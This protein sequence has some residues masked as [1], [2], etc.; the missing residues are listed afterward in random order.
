MLSS[1]GILSAASAAREPVRTI[2]SGP[3]GGVIG[4]L[5][6]AR[7]T[8]ID[9]ILTFDMG[10]TSTDVSLLDSTREPS[11]S[12][13]GQV[14]GLPVGIPM[15]DIHTAGAGGGSLAWIDGAGTLQVGPQSAGAAPGPACYGRGDRATVTDANL[16][17]GRLHPNHF[18]GGAMRLDKSRARKA[19][20]A[21]PTNSFATL[22]HFAEGILRVANAHMEAALRRVS[23]ERGHDPRNFT[24]LAFG[25][26]GPLHACGLAD[27][28][29]I[30]RVLIPAVPGALSA[31][32]IL[33]ADLRREFSRTVMLPLG[34]PQIANVFR[35]LESE[36]RAAFSADGARAVLSRS[37]DL[38]YHGQGF[39]L[40]V[41]WSA[42][43]VARFHRLHAQS[44][45][46]ADP[47][48]AVEI[49][50]LRVQAIVRSRKPRP[51]R[52]VPGK[53]DVRHVQLSTQRT[54]ADG[55]WRTAALYDRAML[56]PGNRIAGPA[57]ITELS[58]TTWLSTGWMAVVDAH[59]NLVLTPTSGARP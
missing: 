40:R 5:S 51:P 31:L 47:A 30:R 39:E 38:R 1:G 3:A 34:S 52:A 55:R 46:Y 16:V 15:L 33:G 42:N 6:I 7:A 25:G 19:L 45:G 9:R 54:F 41:D 56:R 22:E 48:R 43:A 44:Y 8:R 12:T 18:L 14:A 24:L 10:G 57:V 36:A 21:V 53:S 27:A 13:E 29:G 49:V 28:L 11:T 35:V 20:S 59:S 26:A 17:L 4:A 23:V 50:T 58:A 32:G 2:L 37:A